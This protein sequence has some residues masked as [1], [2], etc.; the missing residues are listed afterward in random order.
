MVFVGFTWFLFGLRGFCSVY[1][2][3]VGFT[4]FLLGLRQVALRCWVYATF[5]G[6]YLVGF[7]S[8]SNCEERL[9]ANV[10]PSL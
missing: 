1:A 4:W 2:V 6:Y 9:L 10:L 3:F 7:T 8:S 5:V